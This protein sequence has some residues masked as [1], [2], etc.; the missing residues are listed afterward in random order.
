VSGYVYAL[1][2]PSF[3]NLIKIGKT[4]DLNKRL[5]SLYSSGVPTPFKCI[6]VQEVS[7][8]DKVEKLIHNLLEDDR[9]NDSREF[10]ETSE[11]KLRVIFE[12]IGLP[13]LKK[14][15]EEVDDR[16]LLFL[17]V[18]HLET[19]LIGH[20]VTD[21][22]KLLKYKNIRGRMLP[23]YQTVISRRNK[24]WTL[25]QAFGFQ[26]PPNYTKVDKLIGPKGEGF[27]YYPDRPTEDGNRI[28]IVCN[29]EKKV[30]LSQYDFADFHGIPADY[31]CDKLKAGHSADTILKEYLELEVIR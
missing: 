4:V 12:L 5:S 23:K 8:H 16:P 20:T 19:P 24:G 11:D 30:Y 18:P 3:P 13:P 31:V 6:L 10:F 29:S 21:M 17:Q 9:V 28:P 22:F 26:V 1:T 7:D 14:K 15:T 27:Q 2:N 25:E